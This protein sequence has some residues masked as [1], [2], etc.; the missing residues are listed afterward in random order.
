MCI[1][2]AGSD[3]SSDGKIHFCFSEYKSE[4]NCMI[5]VFHFF[6]LGEEDITITVPPLITYIQNILEN[7]P[8][9]SQILK[10]NIIPIPNHCDP[11]RSKSLGSG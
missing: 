5:I 6:T 11:V 1:L 7:Y 8:D 10:V 3:D 4:I 9:G 2:G